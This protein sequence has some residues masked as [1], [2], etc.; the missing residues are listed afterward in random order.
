MIY[1][2][3]NLSTPASWRLPSSFASIVYTIEMDIHNMLNTK[4]SAA[5]A[6]AVAAG[7]TDQ[8]LTQQVAQAFSASTAAEP[9]SDLDGR[10]LQAL[11]YPSGPAHRST[12]GH[13]HQPVPLLASSSEAPGVQYEN[14]YAHSPT[15]P[16]TQQHLGQALT[17]GASG[18]GEAV[19]AFAC[20]TCHKGFAR[21][22]D[23][24]RHGGYTHVHLS[25]RS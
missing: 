6:A 23:L 20:V 12:Q 21:R 25:S 18:A 17:P 10:R 11:P 4:G 2:I 19:K 13:I 14:G 15:H 8:Q 5:A 9:L 7:A 1:T 24:A 3:C 22:S 16:D